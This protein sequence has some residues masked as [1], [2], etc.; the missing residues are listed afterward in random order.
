MKINTFKYFFVDAMKSLKRNVT[1]TIAFVTIVATTLVIVGLFLLYIMSVNKNA[2]TLFIG[3]EGMSVVLRW[4]EVVLFILLPA[5]SLLLIVNTIKI[6]VFLRKREISIMKFVGAT[7]WFIRWPFII[8]GLVIGII[9][10]FVGTLLLFCIY[11][12]IYT[13]SME[14]TPELILVQPDIVTNTMLWKFIIV[15]AFIG[16]IGSII[17]LRKFLNA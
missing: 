9:G 4:L 5:I 7:N 13:K 16:P 3:N 17:A 1:I 11:S 15:G 6:T 10:A 2:S 12:F 14:F 8:E